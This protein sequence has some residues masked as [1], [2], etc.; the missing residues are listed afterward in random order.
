MKVAEA[1]FEGIKPLFNA[2]IQLIDVE[3][4]KKND[5][6]HLIIYIDKENGVTIDDCVAVS[7]LIDEKLEEL[8][9]T[10]NEPYYLDISSYG[11]DKPLKFD[12]QFKKYYGKLVEVKLYRKV[13]DRKEFVA[14]LVSK[15][16]DSFVFSSNNENFTI[17]NSDVA[18][19]I[20]YI[21]F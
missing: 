4:V 15:N 2:E 18:Y 13:E 17:N 16:E 7:R 1:V 12:W 20:P 8:D 5:G 9:P 3:Y 11:L 6:M 14:T 19:V 10:N 21:E